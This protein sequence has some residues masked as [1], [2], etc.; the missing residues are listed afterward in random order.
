MKAL[1][2]HE[3]GAPWE[4]NMP[5]E[6]LDLAS[7]TDEMNDLEVVALV[8]MRV[9]PLGARHNFAV[10]FHRNTVSLHAKLVNKFGQGSRLSASFR[11]AIHE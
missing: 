3:S 9:G 4:N 10:K 2:K 5:A 7:A 8:Q 11:L 1:K 6:S